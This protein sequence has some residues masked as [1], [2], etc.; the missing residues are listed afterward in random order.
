MQTY[1]GTSK[2][3]VIEYPEP[4]ERHVR[5]VLTEKEILDTYY[6]YWSKGM[7]GVGRILYVT[8]HNCIIDWTVIHWAYEL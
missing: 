8:E 2:K 5:E 6:E 1:L 4:G 7:L 3:W